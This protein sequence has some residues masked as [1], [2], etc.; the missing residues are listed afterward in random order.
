MYIV[1]VLFVSDAVPFPVS[2]FPQISEVWQHPYPELTAHYNMQL[3]N[4]VK[5]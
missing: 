1:Y 5:E 2:H 4:T 3:C